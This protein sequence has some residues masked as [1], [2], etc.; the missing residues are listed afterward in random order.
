MGTGIPITSYMHIC[1]FAAVDSL[2][3]MSFSNTISTENSLESRQKS[4][5]QVIQ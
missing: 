1:I 4:T 2:L 5:P 3:S